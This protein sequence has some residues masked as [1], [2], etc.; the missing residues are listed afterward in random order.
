MPGAA[1][2]ARVRRAPVVPV[3][4]SGQDPAF[5]QQMMR[6]LEA[7]ERAMRARTTPQAGPGAP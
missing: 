2:A 3:T 7:Y 6:G 1:S 4:S 5:M